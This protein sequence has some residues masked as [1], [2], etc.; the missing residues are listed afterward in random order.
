MTKEI[1][2]PDFPEISGYQIERAL[3]EGE[4]ASVYLG[5]DEKHNRKVAIKVF[6]PHYF[7]DSRVAQ[8]YFRQVEKFSIL[9]H[10]NIIA[11]Y[12]TVCQEKL[13]YIV[14]ENLNGSI[15]SRIPDQGK[16]DQEELVVESNVITE[17]TAAP[18][19]FGGIAFQPIMPREALGIV[20][21]IGSALEYA[22]QEGF[23]HRNI[24][25][26]NIMFR[27]DG[28]PVLLNFGV[29]PSRDTSGSDPSVNMSIGTPGY[30]SPEQW[31]K[32]KIDGRSDFYS[33][34]VVLYEML[35][36][37]LPYEGDIPAT[38]G[39]KHLQEPVPTLPDHLSQYQ[40]LIDKMMAKQAEQRVQNHAGLNQIVDS[41]DVSFQEPTL[42]GEGNKARVFQS[43]QELEAYFQPRGES[44]KPADITDIFEEADDRDQPIIHDETPRF[45]K[46]AAD[47]KR[48]FIADFLSDPAKP[49]LVV[50]MIFLLGLA[51]YFLTKSLKKGDDTQPPA[52]TQAVANDGQQAAAEVPSKQAVQPKK[53]VPPPNP[54]DLEYQ[55]NFKQ[56]EDLYK[57]RQYEA[58]LQIIEL[59]KKTKKTKELENLENNIRNAQKKK[60]EEDFQQYLSTAQTEFKRGSYEE[61]LK[62]LELAKKI[63]TN[64]EV[65]ELEQLLNFKLKELEQQKELEQK[66]NQAEVRRDDE[67]FRR[68]SINN[69][70]LS[71]Q[72]YLRK[73][74]DGRHVDEARKRI[75]SLQRGS[76]VPRQPRQTEPVVKVNLR[77]RPQAMSPFQVKEMLKK[78]GF[79]DHLD[80]KAGNFP[81]VFK[82]QVISGDRVIKD[83]V[84]GL[85][86]LPSGS[87]EYM[88]YAK[89]ELWVK[90]F[91][92]T[93]YAGFSD[94]RLP[95]LEEGASLLENQKG[96][97]G[98]FIDTG[99]SG[100][101]SWIWTADPYGSDGRWLVRFDSGDVYG[102][103]TFDSNYVR[104]VRSFR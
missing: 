57:A 24:N 19:G 63:K 4:K 100:K 70:I 21:K 59:A 9:K 86:W 101:Q 14:M 94:W 47:E 30:M 73:F 92:S 72:A 22:H 96:A 27:Q 46:A 20:K 69:T 37:H 58:A 71:Y 40:P 62:N 28:T 97:N 32:E 35:T 33:L 88:S 54:R 81:N 77:A 103:S 85:M 7:E 3:V 78:R 1:A 2:M 51:G 98:L 39:A 65:N 10:P 26:D 45:S 83:E 79:F 15:K 53:Q 95:T 75:E 68:S 55:K 17:D 64:Y 48:G 102:R 29:V 76:E 60:E 38:V 56:A 74:P 84:T 23:F 87:A 90:K 61:S 6:G 5:T 89:A 49:V 12:E 36:G 11:I 25:S 41:V 99:F 18:S 8:D 91:N 52:E 67:T 42:E 16:T 31:R 43:E 66:K 34:G 82:V 93:G 80:N 104:V 50:V 44:H 13:R